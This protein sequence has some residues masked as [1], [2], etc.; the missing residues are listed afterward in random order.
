MAYLLYKPAEYF[1]IVH[2]GSDVT[3]SLSKALLDTTAFLSS[4][5]K[6]PEEGAKLVSPSWKFMREVLIWGSI[7]PDIELDGVCVPEYYTE[8]MRYQQ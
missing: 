8:D 4:I 3:D 2:L 1:D 5:F 7:A 6:D